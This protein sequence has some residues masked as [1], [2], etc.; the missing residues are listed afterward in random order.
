MATESSLTAVVPYCTTG[1]TRRGSFWLF[2]G[3]PA[4]V[5]LLGPL[6]ANDTAHK[7]EA[8]SENGPRCL[9][10]VTMTSR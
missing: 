4:W 7:A 10:T 3:A 5:A 2:W 9:D 8:V 1:D 6:W